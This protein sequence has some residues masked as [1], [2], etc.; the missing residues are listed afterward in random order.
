MKSKN[1][2]LVFLLCLVLTS[3]KCKLNIPKNGYSSNFIN[4]IN[5]SPDYREIYSSS[6]LNPRI[7]GSANA[8]NENNGLKDLSLTFRYDMIRA[9]IVI[10]QVDNNN[11]IFVTN[12]HSVISDPLWGLI[13]LLTSFV[14]GFS[15]LIITYKYKLIKL[16]YKRNFVKTFIKVA[17]WLN[18]F[19]FLALISLFPLISFAPTPYKMLDTKF[20]NCIIV[21]IPYFSIEFSLRGIL[22]YEHFTNLNDW[23]RIKCP[24][25]D[26]SWEKI[27]LELYIKKFKKGSPKSLGILH[28]ATLEWWLNIHDNYDYIKQ[29]DEGK[30]KAHDEFFKSME[31]ECVNKPCWW[32]NEFNV[33]KTT[34]NYFV[35]NSTMLP[36]H[37]GLSCRQSPNDN[38]YYG[39]V[40]GYHHGHGFNIC[41][42]LSNNLSTFKFAWLVF[43]FGPLL[44]I[45]LVY[46]GSEYWVIFSVAVIL[47]SLVYNQTYL[48]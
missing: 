9:H 47:Y 20:K 8:V 29:A 26:K 40:Q 39:I 41:S 16:I 1:I 19:N 36:G 11:V 15:I 35:M 21:D 24:I 27:N 6:S 30:I 22:E 33:V 14:Y 3:Q 31:K 18:I 2:F 43:P 32:Y 13:I 37:S 34:E 44:I 23:I 38:E 45:C 17:L 7:I 46:V 12:Q 5:C 28:N 4:Y 10:E 25:S 42:K 48:L